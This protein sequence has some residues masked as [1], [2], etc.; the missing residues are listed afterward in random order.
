MIIR[1]LKQCTE[2]FVTNYYLW[3]QK[4]SLNF[5]FEQFDKKKLGKGERHIEAEFELAKKKPKFSLTKQ[6]DTTIVENIERYFGEIISR[7]KIN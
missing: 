4:N 7:K 6:K 5:S 1:R 3:S 2:I